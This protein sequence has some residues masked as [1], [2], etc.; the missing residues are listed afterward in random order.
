[1]AAQ[2]V[3]SWVGVL[4]QLRRVAPAHRGRLVVVE[5]AAPER[6]IEPLGP[7]PVPTWHVYVL[8]AALRL[9]GA[10]WREAEVAEPCLQPLCRL[11]AVLAEGTIEVQ[12][13]QDLDKGLQELRDYL[14][15]HPATDAE[16]DAYMECAAR[17]ALGPR[18]WPVVPVSLA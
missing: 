5:R 10:N 17:Q 13:L 8:G 12:A 1:M 11:P 4:A 6:N 15:R 16:L 18:T 9:D 2:K 3:V 14:D 7:E